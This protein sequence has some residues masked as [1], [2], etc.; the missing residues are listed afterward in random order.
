MIKRIFILLA[1]GVLI[2]C[3][4]IAPVSHT[5]DGATKAPVNAGTTPIPEP[6]DLETVAGN[7]EL[8]PQGKIFAKTEFEGVVKKSF[9]R[10]TIIDRQDQAKIYHLYIGDKSRQLDFPWNSQTIQPGYFL[11][12]L[13]AGSYR[14]AS[15]S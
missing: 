10:L 13:P 7:E 14:I 12:D 11:I 8:P 6:V 1:L 15:L 9:I 4:S 5:G 3:K 2:G